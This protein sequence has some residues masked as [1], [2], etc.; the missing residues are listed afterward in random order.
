MDKHNRKKVADFLD[1]D[2]ALRRYIMLG[3]SGFQVIW[4]YQ[5][6]SVSEALF[7]APMAQRRMCPRPKMKL[8][9]WKILEI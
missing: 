3:F 4:V 8:Q 9:T 5:E 1:R 7:K 6:K 2:Y